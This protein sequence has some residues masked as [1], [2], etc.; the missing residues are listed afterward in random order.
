MFELSVTSL[1]HGLHQACTHGIELRSHPIP[2]AIVRFAELV[3][4]FSVHGVHAGNGSLVTSSPGFSKNG[5]T[6]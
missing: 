2:I 6:A 5:W 4:E 1:E 3:A